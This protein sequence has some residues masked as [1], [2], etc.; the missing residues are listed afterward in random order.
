VLL[1]LQQSSFLRAIPA[2]TAAAAAAASSFVWG[3]ESTPMHIMQ[4]APTLQQLR[5]L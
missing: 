2:A 3:A 5:A 1:V 4:H